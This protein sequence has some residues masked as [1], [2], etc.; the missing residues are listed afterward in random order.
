MKPQQIF[1][2]GHHRA[3]YR[4]L[5]CDQNAGTACHLSQIH[6]TPCICNSYVD[7]FT[8]EANMNFFNAW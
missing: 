5:E 3:F 1:R 7:D 8:P 4:W 2:T 6:T